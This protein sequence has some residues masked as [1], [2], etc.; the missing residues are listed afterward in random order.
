MIAATS[1]TN[2]TPSRLHHITGKLLSG[3]VTMHNEPS[4]N[5]EQL[6]ARLADEVVTITHRNLPYRF[7]KWDDW[8]GPYFVVE[9]RTGIVFRGTL[10]YLFECVAVCSAAHHEPHGFKAAKAALP[11]PEPRVRTLTFKE[12][13]ARFTNRFTMEHVPA[14]TQRYTDNGLYYAPQYASDIQWYERTTF[15]GEPGHLGTK[16]TCYS[17]RQTFPLGPW[18]SEPYKRGAQ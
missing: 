17:S 18:L 12:A 6:P 4:Y 14:W 8:N 2:S 15:P 7:G 13:T 1:T 9:L 5:A 10:K 11:E 16:N 3:F